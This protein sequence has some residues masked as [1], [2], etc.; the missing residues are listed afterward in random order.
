[1]SYAPAYLITKFRVHNF[2]N[3]IIATLVE[4]ANGT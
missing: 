4:N 3:V 2:F 1:M